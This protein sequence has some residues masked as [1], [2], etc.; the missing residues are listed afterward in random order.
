MRHAERIHLGVDDLRSAELAD[1]R[2]R[3]DVVGQHDHQPRQ[4]TKGGRQ[5]RAR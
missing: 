3:G 4:V 5:A 1:E 2:R